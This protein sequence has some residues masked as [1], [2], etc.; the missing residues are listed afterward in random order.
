VLA[1]DMETAAVA[2]VC[3]R[4]GRPWSVFR[5]LSDR[6]GDP[7]VGADVLA[8]AGEDGEPDLAAVFR[9]LLRRPWRLPLLVRLGRDSSRATRAAAAA[10]VRALQTL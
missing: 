4:R 9:F 3:E 5:A 6:A 7:L 1:I 8:L 2:A 10:A